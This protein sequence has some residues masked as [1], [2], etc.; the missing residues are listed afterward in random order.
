MRNFLM[1]GAALL[2]VSGVGF[3]VITKPQHVD[4]AAFAALTP[5]PAHGKEVYDAGGCA[6]CH[7]APGAEGE[8]RDVL[9]GGQSITSTFGTFH[10]PNIS[11]DP[12][13]GIGGWSTVD[14][15][16]ALLKGT[17]PDDAHLYPALPYASYTHMLPQDVADL[18]AYL[19]TL[20]ADPTPSKSHE[21]GFPFNIRA[22]LGGWKLFYLKSDWVVTGPLTP[23]EERGRYLAEGPGHCAECHSPRDALGGIDRTRWLGGA[24]NPSGR[25]RIPNIT[26]GGLDWT[27]AD[28][29]EYLTSG[30]TPDFDS[31]G[32]EM[33][34]VID[35]FALLP[36]SD[37]QA[38]AAYLKKVP[39][40][41]TA[42]G[43]G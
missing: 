20:P 41:E 21:I 38:V 42:P 4:A 18:R 19:A 30:F 32:G 1:S 17:G 40:V 7:W 5:D 22:L 36:E 37:R 35:H 33:V 13:E 3:M 8:A 6:S 34:Y 28:I 15:A 24:P 12:A 10:V 29:T 2:L 43:D 23:E 39:A 26:P 16:N 14:L 31:A 9:S 11:S 25:G 27:T